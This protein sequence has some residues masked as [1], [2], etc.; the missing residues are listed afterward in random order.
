MFSFWRGVND[1]YVPNFRATRA[2][3]NGKLKFTYSRKWKIFPLQYLYVSLLL[4]L[5]CFST[6]RYKCFDSFVFNMETPQ[7][8]FR[9]QSDSSLIVGR[10]IARALKQNIRRILFLLIGSFTF[11][12][13]ANGKFKFSWQNFCWT[14]SFHIFFLVSKE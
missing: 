9:R 4:M 6:Y 7:T 5:R 12:G 2:W 10:I 13:M 3:K 14:F 1:T 8:F 11:P